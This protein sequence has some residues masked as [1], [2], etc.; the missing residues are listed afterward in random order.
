MRNLDANLEFDNNFLNTEDMKKFSKGIKTCGK[1]FN[2]IN[3]EILP[4]YTRVIL[5][6]LKYFLFNFDIF[7][8]F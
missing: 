4:N 7:F 8:L 1:F 6:I 5:I 3:R 2:K